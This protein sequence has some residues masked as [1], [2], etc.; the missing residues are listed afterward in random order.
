[1]QNLGWAKNERVRN[2]IAEAIMNTDPAQRVNVLTQLIQRRGM[3]NYLP[4]RGVEVSPLTGV[5]P[6]A[7][8]N[9]MMYPTEATAP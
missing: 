8:V 3:P 9:R 1:M 6:G 4:G 2:E 5:L 7:A